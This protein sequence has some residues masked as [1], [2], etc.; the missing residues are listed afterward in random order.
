MLLTQQLPLATRIGI[1]IDAIMNRLV[2]MNDISMQ[3]TAVQSTEA[4]CE[5]VENFIRSHPTQ[6]QLRA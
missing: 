3:L 4:Y 5:M 1:H 6:V 2:V